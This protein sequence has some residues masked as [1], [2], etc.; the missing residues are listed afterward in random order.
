MTHLSNNPKNGAL[1]GTG[2]DIAFQG[3]YAFAG[4]YDGFTVYDLSDPKEP[5]QALQVYCP[6]SQNDV[7]VYGDILVLSTDSSRSDDSC[8]STT[9]PATEKDAWEGIKVWDISDPLAPE[10]VKSVE[11][12]CGSHTHSLAPTK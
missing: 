8:D 9:R 10:Y 2:S 12:A 5:V 4:N 1:Q 7:S 6:G 3:K 11:T